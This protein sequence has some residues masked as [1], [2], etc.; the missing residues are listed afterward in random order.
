MVSLNEARI[1][2]TM[3]APQSNHPQWGERFILPVAHDTE[4]VLITVKDR[5]L[6]GS[7]FMGKVRGRAVLCEVPVYLSI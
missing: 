5:D 3:V 7:K 6:L 2:H 1:A 4:E